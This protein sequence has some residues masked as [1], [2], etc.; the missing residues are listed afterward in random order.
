M[1]I[2]WLDPTAALVSP[3]T[4]APAQENRPGNCPNYRKLDQREA[5]ASFF[6]EGRGEI[7]S[8]GLLVC[9][10]PKL[11][12]PKYPADTHTL[13]A[14]VDIRRVYLKKRPDCG[15]DCGQIVYT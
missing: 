13:L 9:W 5:K 7:F 14:R 4:R 12:P 8:S 15:Q 10:Y 11:L 6:Y 1:K 3:G 2:T